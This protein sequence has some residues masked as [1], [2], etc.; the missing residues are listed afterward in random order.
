MD[1][2]RSRNVSIRVDETGL[3]NLLPSLL[4]R[5]AL[6]HHHGVRAG[7]CWDDH[8]SEGASSLDTF[9]VHDVLRVVLLYCLAIGV[10]KAIR[11][12]YSGLGGEIITSGLLSVKLHIPFL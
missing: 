11:L 3:F 10:L 8:G 2:L 5:L 1:W 7:A 4:H 9:I 6:V 12:D